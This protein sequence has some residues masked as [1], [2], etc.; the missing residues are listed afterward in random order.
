MAQDG[1]VG[2]GARS[3]GGEGH[4]RHAQ[5]GRFLCVWKVHRS[6]CS[7]LEKAGVVKSGGS[8]WQVQ[9]FVNTEVAQIV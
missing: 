7:I 5:V 3:G 9:D 1:Q 4:P 6:S 2:E 8:E